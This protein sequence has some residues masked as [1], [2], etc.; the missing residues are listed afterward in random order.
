[1][2]KF[3]VLLYFFVGI[4]LF[5][6]GTVLASCNHINVTITNAT[7]LD[8]TTDNDPTNDPTNARTTYNNFWTHAVI[9][10]ATSL[11]PPYPANTQTLQAQ[12]HYLS[13]EISLHTYGPVSGVHYTCSDQSAKCSCSGGVTKQGQHDLDQTQT[14]QI[15]TTA[16]DG[17]V[18]FV[19]CAPGF[20]CNTSG[21]P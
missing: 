2:F 4:N 16:G 1:M 19:V 8:L 17:W 5:Y 7:T 21:S 6:C 3:K 10:G 13:G 11:V 12:E 14:T 9:P 15:L 20:Q 18:S